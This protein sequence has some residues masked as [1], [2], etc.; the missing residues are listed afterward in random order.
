MGNKKPY[1][2]PEIVVVTYKNEIGYVGS[3]PT[4]MEEF[5]AA[6]ED[7]ENYREH[8]M[9]NGGEGFWN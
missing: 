5:F 7:F 1:I 6:D 8:E 4:P 2:A 3:A 9:W